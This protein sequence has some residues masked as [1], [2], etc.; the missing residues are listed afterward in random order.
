M[1]ETPG[2]VNMQVSLPWWESLCSRIHEA[3]NKEKLAILQDW[4]DTADSETRAHGVK[5]FLYAKDPVFSPFTYIP[6][7]C[8]NEEP[9]WTNPQDI[10]AYWNHQMTLGWRPFTN[11]TSSRVAGKYL[12]QVFN[13]RLSIGIGETALNKVGIRL[14]AIPRSAPTE[15]VLEAG[16]VFDTLYHEF[17]RERCWLQE[18]GPKYQIPV[19]IQSFTNPSGGLIWNIHSVSG[20]ALFNLD[21]ILAE[22]KESFLCD[23][24]LS[25]EGILTLEGGDPYSYFINPSPQLSG[26]SPK[27]LISDMEFGDQPLPLK[28]RMALLWNA[29][30]GDHIRVLPLEELDWST[31]L[32]EGFFRDRMLRVGENSL[33]GD[34]NSYYKLNIKSLDNNE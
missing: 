7:D 15:I 29:I 12:R 8:P 33:K 17:G 3:P 14:G 19:L 21:G 20:M 10:I 4:L 22:L 28:Q 2:K 5:L 11:L 31:R 13:K 9:I 1:T 26:L 34:P 23:G 25:M 32:E 6:E 16:K 30:S 24:Y 18:K 27:L